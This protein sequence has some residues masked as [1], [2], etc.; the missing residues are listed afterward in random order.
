MSGLAPLI[1]LEDVSVRRDGRLVLDGVSLALRPGERVAVVGPNGAGKTT[2]LRAIIGL[3]VAH[4]GSL[5]IFGQPCQDEKS[6]QKIRPKVAYL[7]QDSDD[8]LFCPTV[9]EDVAFG[10]LNL[11]LSNKTALAKAQ[12]TLAR[13]ELSSLADR[14]T[15]RLSG[16]EKRL[17]CL[18]GILAM[19]PEVLLLDE[20]TNGLDHNH[21]GRLVRI[22]RT[23]PNAMIIVSHDMPFLAD[24]ATRAL[25]LS[26]SR[27]INGTI[28]RHPHV[29]D[30]V[31]I[32]ADV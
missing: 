26:E 24:L 8:Q 29:H 12:E 27:L 23:L 13:M 22:L 17:I 9:L 6:F 10:P 4:A 21:Y 31:H 15:Y 11:G 25:V 14:V 19:E 1:V 7:F 16:G 20:P 18:A 2:L 5:S 28:H 32:H 30:H 3:D